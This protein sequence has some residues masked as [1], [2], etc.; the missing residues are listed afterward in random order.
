MQITPK[1]K[2]HLL[3]QKITE[4]TV[5]EVK[6]KTCCSTQK[7]P[8]VSI[9][10]NFTKNEEISEKKTD[11]LNIFFVEGAQKYSD[12]GIIDLKE[13]GNI[14]TLIFVEPSRSTCC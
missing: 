3:D 4:I 7:V 2:K 12:S 5:L 1:A 11:N 9:G 8:R 10:K 6:I 14:K 13:F